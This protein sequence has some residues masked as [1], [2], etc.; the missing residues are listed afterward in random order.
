LLSL[1]LEAPELIEGKDMPGKFKFSSINYKTARSREIG[2]NAPPQRVG[3][4]SAHVECTYG[5]EWNARP[6]AGIDGVLGGVVVTYPAC[7][8]SASVSGRQLGI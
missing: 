3:I 1:R 4:N 8:T 7:H 6:G 2:S 5:H